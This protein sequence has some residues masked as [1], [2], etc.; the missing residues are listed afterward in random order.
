MYIE[1]GSAMVRS[2]AA[3]ARRRPRSRSVGVPSRLLWNENDV[4]ARPYRVTGRV[5]SWLESTQVAGAL[6][7]AWADSAEL[8]DARIG[9]G[10]QGQARKSKLNAVCSSSGRR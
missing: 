3:R 5:T 1:P 9:P 4:S 7:G 10:S 6:T 2:A 8:I